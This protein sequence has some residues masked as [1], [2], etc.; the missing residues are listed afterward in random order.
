[1]IKLTK[2]AK[3][4]SVKWA[5]IC[6]HNCKLYN[7][8]VEVLN[9]LASRER[10]SEKIEREKKKHNLNLSCSCADGSEIK[11]NIG[12]RNTL[13]KRIASICGKN[14]YF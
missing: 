13:L 7:S 14:S 6:I 11:T 4:P 8:R 5:F 10:K 12:G 1:M 3:L 9:Y 2:T